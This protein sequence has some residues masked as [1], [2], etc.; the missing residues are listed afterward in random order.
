MKKINLK[1]V[2]ELCMRALTS[3]RVNLNKASAKSITKVIVAAERDHAKSHGLFRL[4]GYCSGILHHKVNPRVEPLVKDVS[5][6]AIVTDAQGGYSPLAF[7]RSLPLLVQKSKLNGVAVLAIR[8]SFHFAALWYECEQLAIQ[9]ELASIVVVNSKSYVAHP[10]GIGRRLYG[11]NPMAFGYPR[12]NGLYPMIIDQASSK[13]AR[14]EI[15]MLNES[16]SSSSSSINNLPNDVGVNINGKPTNNAKEVLAGAQLPFGGIKGA[17]VALM[18]ELLASGM[19]GSPFGYQTHEEDPHW[20]GP[21]KQGEFII[22]MDPNVFQENSKDK[23]HLD[24][25]EDLFQRLMEDGGRIPGS[26]RHE[27]RKKNGKKDD[28]IV[29]VSI[30]LYNEI[31]GIIN[32]MDNI[33]QGYI[34]TEPLKKRGRKRV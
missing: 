15:Q 1:Q 26:R 23:N 20:Y 32:G 4:P 13:M 27:C 3:P 22:A 28:C 18:V 11:T 17:N 9:H 12:R 21:T 25:V 33:T 8:N 30:N 19:T 14:G 2:S 24:H 29:D 10:G 16:S 6:S 31:N 5:I 7:E 34:S